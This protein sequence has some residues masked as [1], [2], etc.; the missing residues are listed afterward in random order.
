MQDKEIVADALRSPDAL[1]RFLRTVEPFI[2]QTAYYLTGKKADAEDITQESLWKVCRSL[3][4]YQGQGSLRGWIH[5]VVVNTFREQLRKKRVAVVELD[6]GLQSSESSVEQQVEMKMT[7][8]RLHEA[9][10]ALPENYR[11]VIV[12][13][14]V[15]EMSYQEIGEVLE[16]TEAQVKT[17]LFRGREKLKTLFYG[18]DQG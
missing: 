1:S 9:I 15:H 17:R 13:R 14:H 12:L 5:R 4:Q 11:E 6:E 18:G 7:E 3:G 10:A 16:L 2:Y 8:E